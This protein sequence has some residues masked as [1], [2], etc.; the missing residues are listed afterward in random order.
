MLTKDVLVMAQFEQFSYEQIQIAQGFLIDF[1][2]SE[3]GQQC[4]S[5][6]DG[7]AACQAS[8]TMPPFSACKRYTA[9][10]HASIVDEQ[11][12]A[13]RSAIDTAKDRMPTVPYKDIKDVY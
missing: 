3:S 7:S 6:L 12:A 5:G 11:K 10:S 8:V 9:S 13:G 1:T 2:L 4:P